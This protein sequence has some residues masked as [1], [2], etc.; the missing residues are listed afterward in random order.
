M[1]STEQ[2]VSLERTLS[3]KEAKARSIVEMLAQLAVMKDR[4]KAS[5]ARVAWDKQAPAFPKQGSKSVDS[6]CKETLLRPSLVIRGSHLPQSL[7]TRRMPLPP[8]IAARP[9]QRQRTRTSVLPDSST[10]FSLKLNVTSLATV[11][12]LVS[13]RLAFSAKE[14]QLLCGWLR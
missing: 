5:K 3:H 2:Q 9:R 1:L 8:R 14:E 7:P 6:P 4:P 11:V 10:T 12:L 13:E